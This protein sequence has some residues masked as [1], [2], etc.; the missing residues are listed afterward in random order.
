MSHP[1][2]PQK[3]IA[4]NCTFGPYCK[5]NKKGAC[6]YTHNPALTIEEYI[7]TSPQECKWGLN[8]T[9][10][11]EGKCHFVHTANRTDSII[12]PI[13]PITIKKA[14]PIIKTKKD[15]LKNIIIPPPL[16]DRQKR[17]LAL[18]RYKKDMLIM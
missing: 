11:A 4:K 16:T 5:F 1:Y 17:L 3:K 6:R 12:E 13:T 15:E 18:R 7:L 14:E 10:N 2:A 9:F 8:C